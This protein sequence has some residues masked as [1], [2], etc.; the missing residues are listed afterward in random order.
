MANNDAKKFKKRKPNRNNRNTVPADGGKRE[1]TSRYAKSQDRHEVGE[2]NRPTPEGGNH[3]SWYVPD[4][5]L[6]NDVAA[7]PFNYR[8]GDQMPVAITHNAD[9]SISSSN[10][11][12]AGILGTYFT[13]TY[14]DLSAPNSPG[15]VASQA[16]Y[17]W[18]RHA[19]SGARNYDA[20][21]LMIYLLAM[22][23]IYMGLAWCQRL[24]ATVMMFN[25]RNTYTPTAILNSCGVSTAADIYGDLPAMRSKLNQMILKATTLAV[26][27]TLPIYDRHTF[28]CSNIYVDEPNALGQYYIFNPSVLWKFVNM[29]D[30]RGALQAV[31]FVSAASLATPKAWDTMFDIVDNLINAVYSDEDAGI[32]SGDMLKAYGEGNL[33]KLLTIPSDIVAVPVY[34]HEMLEQIHNSVSWGDVMGDS[35]ATPETVSAPM[36]T[37]YIPSGTTSPY[38]TNRFVFDNAAPSGTTVSNYIFDIHGD[39]T[40]EMVMRSSRL[41]SWIQVKEGNVGLNANST[42]ATEVVNR[43]AVWKYTTEGTLT[44]FQIAGLFQFMG[45][46]FGDGSQGKRFLINWSTFSMAPIIYIPYNLSGEGKAFDYYPVGSLSKVTNLSMANLYQLNQVATLGVFN[47][48]RL[49]LGN[50]SNS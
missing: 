29:A 32:M 1:T 2:L 19:N 11:I 37:Q 22:D 27:R 20:V 5:N 39:T 14:G 25:A 28:M 38:L 8:V 46:S 42:F 10:Y 23:S 47:V 9:N 24:V 34:D 36:I 40:P 41:T 15:N 44:N 12:M 21:D 16:V 7:I 4:S 13:P 35:S 17:S 48:P 30:G 43:H 31:D 33:F 18:V 26:P 45:D 50:V 49:T 6:L 3:I